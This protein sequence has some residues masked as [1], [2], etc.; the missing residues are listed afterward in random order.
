MAVPGHRAPVGL[1]GGLGVEGACDLGRWGWGSGEDGQHSHGGVELETWDDTRAS[2]QV[3]LRTHFA[4]TRGLLIWGC[5][6]TIEIYRK[7]F[8]FLT[9]RNS[10]IN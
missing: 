2:L 4:Q 10:F 5:K 8:K 7:T 1:E 9:K 6:R 3:Q